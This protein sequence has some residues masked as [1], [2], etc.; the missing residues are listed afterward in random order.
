MNKNVLV[1][2]LM[3]VFSLSFFLKPLHAEEPA[4]AETPAPAVEPAAPAEPA[5]LAEDETEFSFGTVKSVTDNQLIVSEYDY[6]SNADVDVPYEVSADTEFE[7]AASLKD[8]AAGDSVDV[9][10]LA[11]DGKKKAVAIT[12]EKPLTE[13]EE[14]D[15]EAD[16]EQAP[17]E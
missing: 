11:V 12:V 6:E 1:A 14:A 9:D 8:V 17:K 3:A 2:V 10:F 4:P 7:N 16:V 15:L 5:E 13:E